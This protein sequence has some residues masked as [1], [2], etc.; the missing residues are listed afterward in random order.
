MRTQR[1]YTGLSTRQ[2]LTCVEMDVADLASAFERA[3]HEKNASIIGGADPAE[4]IKNGSAN[5]SWYGGISSKQEAHDLLA[6]GWKKGAREVQDLARDLSVE[7]PPATDIRRRPVWCEDGDD[8]CIDRALAGAWDT[9]FRRA[10]RER[11][12]GIPVITLDLGWGGNCNESAQ[13]LLYS[14]AT[15]LVCAN[16]LEQAGYA[17]R[18][19]ASLLNGPGWGAEKSWLSKTSIVIKE[20]DTPTDIC[21]LAGVLCHAGVFRSLGFAEIAQ[22]PYDVGGGFG[23]MREWNQLES[24]LKAADEWDENAI[25]INPAFE[26]HSA[27]SEIERV[28]KSLQSNTA[29]E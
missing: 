18:I 9:A 4:Q 22:L 1:D 10:K 12:V 7:I 17:V 21:N 5:R 14:G 3:P 20:S 28:I 11:S 27:I 15:I 23:R 19:C 25:R 24:T 8:L 16:V 2:N 13:G 26:R 29:P 6:N